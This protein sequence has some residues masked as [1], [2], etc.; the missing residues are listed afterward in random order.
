[1]RLKKSFLI[2]VC[3]CAWSL[4]IIIIY[5]EFILIRQTDTG[6]DARHVPF[7]L[8][9]KR[10]K[11][12]FMKKRVANRSKAENRLHFKQIN[13][14]ESNN[15]PEYLKHPKKMAKNPPKNITT[16][17]KKPKTNPD[18]ENSVVLDD[19][20]NNQFD[21]NMIENADQLIGANGTESA[22]SYLD[23]YAQLIARLRK[24]NKKSENFKGPIIPVL[25]IACNRISV[26]SCLDDLVR[27]R[28]NAHQFPIIVSQV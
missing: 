15:P 19:K 26:K 20:S 9:D 1:M 12:W 13:E 14:I 11:R 27:Y 21:S 3:L 18:F 28:P 6:Q 17:E 16:T 7:E 2:A 22:E 4:I 23:E 8:N 10:S 24:L 25:V 5:N